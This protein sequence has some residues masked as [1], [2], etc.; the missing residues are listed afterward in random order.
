MLCQDYKLIERPVPIT[1]Q[2]VHS[3]R[4]L[5][6][7][8]FWLPLS[9][10]DQIQVKIQQRGS[11]SEFGAWG[12]SETKP[13][14]RCEICLA[15]LSAPASRAL[16][17]CNFFFFFASLLIILSRLGFSFLDPSTL[18]QEAFLDSEFTGRILDH[19]NPDIIS[20]ILLGSR[21]PSAALRTRK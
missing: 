21:S 9:R 15:A 5:L 20:L 3:A 17:P 18:K 8:L 11:D 4:N 12:P 6:E 10:S 16:N 13:A 1:A 14:V 19:L 7:L 2:L